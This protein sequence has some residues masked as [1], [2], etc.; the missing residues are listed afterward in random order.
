MTKHDDETWAERRTREKH[1]RFLN[2]ITEFEG[3]LAQADVVNQNKVCYTEDCLK[4]A[5]ERWQKA[6]QG[7]K[8][9]FGAPFSPGL[10]MPVPLK[11]I[12]FQVEHVEYADNELRSRQK[13]L[14]T[15]NGEV[16]SHLLQLEVETP[17]SFSVGMGG[18]AH[19][20]EEIDGVMHVKDFEITRVTIL[21]SKEK[22]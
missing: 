9:M 17:G 7:G 11:E 5:A 10:D 14:A 15:P 19:E 3:V 12:G 13:L 6:Q 18:V 2:G 8:S 1:L 16:C 20:T 22:A 4:K 21:P